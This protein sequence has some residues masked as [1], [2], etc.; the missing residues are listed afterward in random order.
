[1]LSHPYIDYVCRGS[2]SSALLGKRGWGGSMSTDQEPT[3]TVKLL[4]LLL[5]STYWGMQI[6]VTFISS[7]YHTHRDTQKHKWGMMR[8]RVGEAG[9]SFLVTCY[10]DTIMTE[11]FFQCGSKCGLSDR[12]SVY[13]V[14]LGVRLHLSTYDCIT[15][16]KCA[17]DLSEAPS[18]H[19]VHPGP[20]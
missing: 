7:W 18:Y 2:G 5:L 1:M 20:N 19:L 17:Q 16:K 9:N 15:Q 12:I 11:V 8:E 13:W 4:Q 3:F 14:H 6:W 10:M